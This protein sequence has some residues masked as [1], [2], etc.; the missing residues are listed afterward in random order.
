MRVRVLAEEAVDRGEV[1]LAV[2][3]DIANAFNTLPWN[4]IKEALR[5]H[6]VP[7]YLRRIIG[8]Y[9]SER[10]V[11][12][13]GR[14]GWGRQNISSSGVGSRPSLVEHWLRLGP[15]RCASPRRQRDMLR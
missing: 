4:I 9:L 14:E 15:A 1:V 8:A 13:P 6:G 11:V 3:H 2:S 7:G 5:Y 12:Y 10:A